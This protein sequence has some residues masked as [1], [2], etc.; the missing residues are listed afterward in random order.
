MKTNL[1][2][3]YLATAFVPRRRIKKFPKKFI[4]SSP[5]CEVD[6]NLL[7]TLLKSIIKD[8]IFKNARI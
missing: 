1:G 3:I 5:C 7:E 4:I 8:A 6:P 2:I